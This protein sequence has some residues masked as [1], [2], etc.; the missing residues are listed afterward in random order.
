VH[1][2]C[3]WTNLQ[4]SISCGEV[5]QIS[6]F[7]LIFL[8]FLDFSN[9][10]DQGLSKN[11]KNNLVASLGEFIGTFL[12]PFFGFGGTQIANLTTRGST[13]TGPNLAALT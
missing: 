9:N 11:I 6:A 7:S 13:S 2:L 1:E 12:F 10:S 4:Y 3:G 8:K 5:T